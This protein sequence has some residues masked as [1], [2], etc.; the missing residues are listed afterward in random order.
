MYVYDVTLMQQSY[1][2]HGGAWRMT[3][4]S[5]HVFNFCQRSTIFIDDDDDHDSDTVTV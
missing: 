5:P 3:S 2:Q 1:L 4:L